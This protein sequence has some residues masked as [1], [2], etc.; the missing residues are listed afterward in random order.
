MQRGFLC[1]SQLG[2]GN[3]LRV[4]LLA[5]WEAGDGAVGIPPVGIKCAVAFS[6]PSAWH[7]LSSAQHFKGYKR[8]KN[9]IFQ[10]DLFWFYI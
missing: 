10:A 2:E 6:N 9:S 5:G 7:C 4:E 8:G 3:R 1:L